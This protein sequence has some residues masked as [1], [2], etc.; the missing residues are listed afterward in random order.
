VS[1][2]PKEAD[3]IRKVLDSGRSVMLYR[4]SLGSYTAIV[5]GNEAPI[6]QIIEEASDTGRD[7]TDD[8]TPSQALYRLA[9]KWTTGRIA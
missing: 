2:T 4:N 3:D 7:I 5:I 6:N 1:D 8:F 9:E